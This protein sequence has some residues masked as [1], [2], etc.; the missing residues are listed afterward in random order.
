MDELIQASKKL[1]GEIDRVMRAEDGNI[2]NPCE[3]TYAE[4]EDAWATLIIYQQEVRG[5]LKHFGEDSARHFGRFE[6]REDEDAGRRYWWGAEDGWKDP[7][8]VGEDG[9]ITVDARHFA[10]GA[11]LYMSEPID[12]ENR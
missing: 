5:I 1:V 4:L 2:V 9:V 12:E 10:I 8:E 11:V 7:T 3:E 6:V